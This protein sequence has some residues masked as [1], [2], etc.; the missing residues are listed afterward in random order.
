MESACDFLFEEDIS[1]AY[2][3]HGI[4]RLRNSYILC[5]DGIVWRNFKSSEI[6]HLARVDALV[7]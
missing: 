3:D 1:E 5:Q 6:D 2:L 4:Y 7:I